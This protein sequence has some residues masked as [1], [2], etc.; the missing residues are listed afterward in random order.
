M[1]L[2]IGTDI[3]KIDRFISD[4]LHMDRL[5]NKILTDYELAEYNKLPDQQA[6]YLAKKWSAKE[7]ISKAFGTGISGDTKWKSIEIRHNQAG[8]PVVCFYNNLKDSV[9][10]LQ[11]KCHLSVSDEHDTVVAYS[12]IEYSQ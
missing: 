11:A 4:K 5:A 7:S 6:I 9:E 10:T 2:G 1:I 12:I 3:A 8:Q